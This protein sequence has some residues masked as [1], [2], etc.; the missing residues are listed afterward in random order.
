MAVFKRCVVFEH[1]L[2]LW[3]SLYVPAVRAVCF[4]SVIKRCVMF[5]VSV[6]L[7]NLENAYG[8]AEAEYAVMAVFKRCVAVGAVYCI[9]GSVCMFQRLV[10]FA[11]SLAQYVGSSG[12]CCLLCLW[13]IMYVQAA[14]AVCWVSGCSSMRAVGFAVLCSGVSGW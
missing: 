2:Y 14:R 10:M 7:M 9:S 13:L 8:G 1:L 12:T 3:L 4:F 11:V 6:K 5:V